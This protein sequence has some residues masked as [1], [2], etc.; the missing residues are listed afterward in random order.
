VAA[1]LACASEVVE[2]PQAAAFAF[3]IAN[4][5]VHEVELG[6]LA[7]IR[8]RKD[9]IEDSLEA[10]IIPFRG[11]KVHLEKSFVGSPLNL[12]EVGD[13]DDGWNFGEIDAL[14]DSAVPTV[15]HSICSLREFSK[16]CQ[17]KMDI[18]I[19]YL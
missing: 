5:V 15:K 3:P 1:V 18:P 19:P 8:N 10:D 14:A 16:A 11:Q 13:L 12:D 6:D 4:R 17:T 7:K 2:T 9:G